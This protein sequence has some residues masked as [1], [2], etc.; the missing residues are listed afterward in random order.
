MTQPP[1]DDLLRSDDDPDPR[2]LLANERTL[3][4]WMR[5]SLALLAAAAAVTAVDLPMSLWLQRLMS[6]V[7]AVVALASVVL[8]WRSARRRDA[9]LRRHEPLPEA[10]GATLVV[11]GL[12][13]VGVVLIVAV[14]A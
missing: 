14:L 9:A 11:I 1:P 10:R 2:V 6:V 8:G 7:L 3:L 5:T 13:F 12:L 4:A